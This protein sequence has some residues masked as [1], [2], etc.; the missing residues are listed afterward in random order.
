MSDIP[1][2]CP[3]KAG[4]RVQMHGHP[5]YHVHHG[6]HLSALDVSGFRGTVEGYVG[7][8]IL[9]GTRDDGQPWAEDWGSLHPDLT[10]CGDARCGCCPHPNGRCQ[11]AEAD[12]DRARQAAKAMAEWWRTGIR[13]ARPEPVGQLALFG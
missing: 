6:R 7:A 1:P 10:R 4:D 2:H 13:P 9:T 5:G 3:Y 8:T 11:P 12:A